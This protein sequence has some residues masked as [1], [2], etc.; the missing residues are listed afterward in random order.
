VYAARYEELCRNIAFDQTVAEADFDAALLDSP[1]VGA[2]PA[3]AAL[4]EEYCN[5]QTTS[6]GAQDGMVAQMR[7]KLGAARGTPPD[8]EELARS[9]Q[10]STRTLRRCL[11]QMSTSYSE[12]LDESRR[13]RAEEWVKV[14]PMTFEVIAQ[15]LGFSS[16]RS[17]RRAFKRWTGFTPGAVRAAAAE[18]R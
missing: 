3:T 2:D 7:R 17:F 6:V 5:R 18:P 15:E 1:I 12:L 9:L 11:H 10:T 16:V 14:T 8:L 13:T 4:A